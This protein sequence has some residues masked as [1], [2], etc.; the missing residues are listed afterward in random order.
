MRIRR[1][2]G[3]TQSK[4]SATAAPSVIRKGKTE[5][6]AQFRCKLAARLVMNEDDSVNTVS[7]LC[8]QS[9]MARIDSNVGSSG[10]PLVVK[11]HMFCAEVI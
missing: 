4:A 11:F 5:S 1:E 10:C 6:R 3:A 7:L 2:Y 8:K 9:E